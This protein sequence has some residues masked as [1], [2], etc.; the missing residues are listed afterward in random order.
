MEFYQRPNSYDISF[1]LL[2]ETIGCEDGYLYYSVNGQLVVEKIV[3]LSE[4]VIVLNSGKQMDPRLIDASVQ[5]KLRAHFDGFHK[6]VEKFNYFE[7]FGL[8]IQ[9]DGFIHFLNVLD[10]DF[11]KDRILISFKGVE[12]WI[13]ASSF[14]LDYQK[15]LYVQDKKQEFMGLA[16]DGLSV[17]ESVLLN[18]FDNLTLQTAR[19]QFSKFDFDETFGDL[20]LADPQLVHLDEF[21]NGL[22]SLLMEEV[23]DMAKFMKLASKLLS[24]KNLFRGLGIYNQMVDFIERVVPKLDLVVAESKI[25]QIPRSFNK[26]NVEM[27]FMSWSNSLKK[28][29]A[30]DR[31]ELNEFATDWLKN[32]LNGFVVD[33]LVSEKRLDAVFSGFDYVNRVLGTRFGEFVFGHQNLKKSV[34]SAMQYVQM[35]KLYLA[36]YVLLDGNVDKLIGKS[37]QDIADIVAG[38]NVVTGR[39]A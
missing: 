38:I 2:L 36:Q 35:R 37:N 21:M 3:S 7:K 24:K 34:V 17:L 39:V 27:F 31:E 4:Q 19:A 29:N 25:N 10:T 15:S 26:I 9:K 16:G 18:P 30:H 11:D 33:E 1:E 23:L 12:R 5:R 14:D 32:M 22:R 13:D 6:R 20:F 28:L 8:R